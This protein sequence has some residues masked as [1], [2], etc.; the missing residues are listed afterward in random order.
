LINPLN[1][2]DIANAL[3][4]VTASAELRQQMRE[5]GLRRVLSLTWR[6]T[7]RRTLAVFNEIVPVEIPARAETAAL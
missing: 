6:E 7:A 5:L 3:A 2:E 1:E 4:E